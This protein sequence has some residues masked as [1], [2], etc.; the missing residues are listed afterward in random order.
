MRYALLLSAGLCFFSTAC[1]R[2]DDG[3]NNML[4]AARPELVDRLKVLHVTG[5]LGNKASGYPV[6]KTMGVTSSH[7][8]DGS[9]STV[10]VDGR[11][12]IAALCMPYRSF[13]ETKPVPSRKDWR[14]LGNVQNS[15]RFEPN[16]IDPKVDLKIGGKVYLGGFP[17]VYR[18]CT[19]KEFLRMKPLVL[20]GTIVELDAKQEEWSGLVLVQVPEAR[21]GGFSGGPAAVIDDAGNIRV[22][23]TIVHQGYLSYGWFHREYV[24]CV[25]PLPRDFMDLQ[26][27]QR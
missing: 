16:V 6:S 25:A 5:D 21:Y 2:P 19:P 10:A 14:I 13:N 4:T 17:L 24:L 27:G 7:L 12:M 1:R 20:E 8:V 26:A 23:G 18:K 11:P 15:E 9:S 22:W 3:L